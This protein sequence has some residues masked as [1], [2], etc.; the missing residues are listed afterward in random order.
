[1]PYK[2]VLAGQS[3]EGIF[4][5]PLALGYLKVY[6]EAQPQLSGRVSIELLEYPLWGSPAESVAE[7]I[8]EGGPELIGFSC[9]VWNADR[10]MDVLAVLR[11]RAPGIRIVLGGPEASC[12]AAR[13]IE[14]GGADFVVHGEGEE[15]FAELLELLIDGRAPDSVPGLILGKDGR[16]APFKPRPAMKDLDR[17]PCPYQAG[18]FD[19]GPD[20][21]GG[22]VL[23][24]SRGC[25]FDCSYCDWPGKG[26]KWFFSEGRVL[27]TVNR[28]LAQTPGASINLPDSDIFLKKDRASRILAGFREASD[29]KPVSWILNAYPGCLDEDTGKHCDSESFFF[30]L[31]IQTHNLE[32]LKL[33]SRPTDLDKLDEKMALLK[34]LAPRAHLSMQLIYGLP[35]DSLAEY[36]KSIDWCLRWKPQTC[37]FFRFLVLGGTPFEHDAVRLGIEYDRKPSFKVRSTPAF[38][39]KDVERAA[40]LSFKVSLFWSGPAIRSA[41]CAAADRGGDGWSYVGAVDALERRLSRVCPGAVTGAF[42]RWRRQG[43]DDDGAPVWAAWPYGL[44]AAE[45]RAA[46]RE[47][48]DELGSTPELE[49]ELAR[50]EA[51]ERRHDNFFD[52]L[53]GKMAHGGP[54]LVLCRSSD[55]ALLKGLGTGPSVLLVDQAGDLGARLGSLRGPYSS[56]ILL[57]AYP[58][59]RREDRAAVLRGLS[60]R[61]ESG[62]R[63]FVLDF[64]EAAEASDL[65]HDGWA[66]LG[67]SRI[68]GPFLKKA[69]LFAGEAPLLRSRVQG[70]HLSEPPPNWGGAR[71][72]LRYLTGRK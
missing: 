55:R 45:Q 21:R 50:L 44:S 11:K 34:E 28:I 4:C 35:G 37:D 47:A 57:N 46:L 6:A 12:H 48:A 3:P 9:Y 22:L 16:V 49:R 66:G 54:T 43:G 23:E 24:T 5:N 60:E 13:F 25:P 27:E 67:W 42:E 19:Y 56:V 72:L 61:T 59:I 15:T 1:M 29:R 38:P 7:R 8:L 26:G 71:T 69:D 14:E 40:E 51:E 65:P 52:Q 30:L 32:A 10:V 18:L 63:L 33:S 41:L 2:V 36:R 68:Q 17:I 70:A 62:G 39:E 20:Y 64:V 58:S 53:L 31:G